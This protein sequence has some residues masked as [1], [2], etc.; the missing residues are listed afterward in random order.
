VKETFMSAETTAGTAAEPPAITEAR[1]VID[2]LLGLVPKT[3]FTA[4]DAAVAWLKGHDRPDAFLSMRTRDLMDA[5]DGQ[6]QVKTA[7]SPDSNALFELKFFRDHSANFRR[8]VFV[9]IGFIAPDAEALSHASELRIL[10][11]ALANGYRPAFEAQIR[12]SRIAPEA[13]SNAR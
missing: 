3:D 6:C 4:V 7:E 12:Y 1:R 11:Q 9:G 13:E 2:H 8:R 10:R 5:A